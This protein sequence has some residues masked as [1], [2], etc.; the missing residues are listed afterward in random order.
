VAR[1]TPKKKLEEFILSDSSR[2]RPEKQ[3]YWMAIRV[4]RLGSPRAPVKDC[5][6]DGSPPPRGVP[7]RACV[8]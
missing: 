8:A 1:V 5:D 3:E 4:V 7:R 2:R 6:W